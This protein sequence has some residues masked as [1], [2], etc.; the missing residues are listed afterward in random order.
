[1]QSK[2]GW[3][4]SDKVKDHFKNPRNILEDEKT[5][6]EDGKGFVGNPKCG[7]MMM[8]A[9]KVDSASQRIKECKWQTYGCASAIGSTS[10][11][12]EMVSRDGG[13]TLEEARKITPTQIMD[14][15]G[16]LPDNKIHCSVLGDKALRDAINDY[17][18]RSGNQG[19]IHE[20][21]SKV[22]CEC[23]NV[24]DHD[25]EEEVLEGVTS[26][27]QLQERTKIST[28]CGKCKG[29]ATEAFDKYRKK[30]FPH[31]FE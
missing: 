17:Y 10:M 26:F 29:E 6:N 18:K 20:T 27:E 31:H 11:L 5:Y 13:M 16:G 24:T 7:D 19:K 4:Y 14:E 12:S 9:I 28:G 30:H 8:M 21:A 23:L 15:L 25:I 22:I 3:L 2:E 1:M